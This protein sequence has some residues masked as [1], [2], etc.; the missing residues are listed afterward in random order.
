M[1]FYDKF[2]YTNFQEINLDRIIQQ[3]VEVQ[4]GLQFVIDNA[5]L[6]YADPIQWNIT[7]QYQANTVVIDPATGIAYIS[8]KPVPSNI[9]ITDPGYWTPIFDLSALFDDI[10]ADVQKVADDLTAETAA[11]TDA[12]TALQ[13]NITAEETARINA[14]AALQE[15]IDNIHT[16]YVNVL[17]YGA[18]GDGIADDSLA[19]MAA[20]E[21]GHKMVYLPAGTYNISQT[22]VMPTHSGLIGDGAGSMIRS[23]VSN[24]DMVSFYGSY[25]VL[26]DLAFGTS[27]AR[28]NTAYCV[29]TDQNAHGENFVIDN[30]IFFEA[31]NT[32]NTGC[33][34]FL[35]GMHPLGF[36]NNCK[37]E[38]R[39]GGY[40]I[41]ITGGNDR[42]ITNCWLRGSYIVA[43]N[44]NSHGQGIRIEGS[45]GDFFQ[46]I[47]VVQFDY[48]L[49]I[50][51]DVR[52]IEVLKFNQCLFD[53]SRYHTAFLY[54]SQPRQFHCCTFTSCWFA[55]AGFNEGN[56][57][58]ANGVAVTCSSGAS[59]RDI[60]FDDCQFHNNKCN[61]LYVLNTGGN[62]YGFRINDSSFE[63]NALSNQSA[64]SD[65]ST[66][67]ID[68]VQIQGNLF[69]VHTTSP[70][71]AYNCALGGNSIVTGNMF[72]ALTAPTSQAGSGNII[73]QNITMTN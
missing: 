51:T 45:A 1:A 65:I 60:V 41:H 11:R 8:T 57:G 46:N 13:N 50:N 21:G 20:L 68:Y 30:V 6:K 31:S 3:L 18:K 23:T 54:N 26:K 61:G 39:G 14:D 15:E 37:F 29:T 56:V 59:V 10:E 33:G 49:I 72:R 2:P 64:F 5:S 69:N 17:N 25:H 24:I 42:F 36:I 48:D 38:I 35:S 47:D 32:L 43:S 63:D 12:D 7:R 66:A 19:I 22:I 53:S 40:G 16:T 52:A 27:V 71:T 34:I 58:N 55:G 62:M 28:Q 9:L 70:K 44:F 4:E 73:E 67:N